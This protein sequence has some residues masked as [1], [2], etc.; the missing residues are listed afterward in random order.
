MSHRREAPILASSGDV[1]NVDHSTTHS[2]N[3]NYSLQLARKPARRS[4]ARR[5]TA[6]CVASW[7]TSCAVG[8]GDA[9]K[10]VAGI[11]CR[12]DIYS[13]G[14]PAE[15]PVAEAVTETNILNHR[16]RSGSCLIAKDTILSVCSESDVILIIWVSSLNLINQILIPK[17]LPD[18]ANGSTCKSV[19]RQ[20]GAVDV[21]KH[22]YVVG[23][24]AIVTWEDGL[25]L[26][27]AIRIGLL[28]PTEESGV[29]IRKIIRIAIS[30][31]DNTRV[32]TSRV[33]VPDVPVESLNWLA[34]LNIHEL[35]I[36]ND[37]NTWLIA[38]DVGPNVF[39]LGL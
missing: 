26:N 10:A 18:V 20:E 14:D 35:P 4:G 31:R 17:D 39:S 1:A 22:M 28:N 32:N 5:S 13:N 34:C 15:Q 37:W 11:V 16:V 19:V 25:E 6:G 30:I 33:A 21:S 9:S 23:A 29:V 38:T 27:N 24:A 3:L 7:I 8:L 36:Q 2:G 12:G